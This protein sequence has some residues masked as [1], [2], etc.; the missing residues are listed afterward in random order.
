MNIEIWI[1]GVWHGKR[2]YIKRLKNSNGRRQ[3]SSI[4][5]LGFDTTN[6][7]CIA[8][9]LCPIRVCS[10]FAHFLARA[11]SLSLILSLTFKKVATL[12]RTSPAICSSDFCL[13]HVCLCSNG[14]DDFIE[15]I[16][17]AR[18]FPAHAI[19]TLLHN[20]HY[21]AIKSSPISDGTAECVRNN[22]HSCSN[23][24]AP[25][26][27]PPLPSRMHYIM[28]KCRISVVFFQRTHIPFEWDYT[29]CFVPAGVIL[30]TVGSTRTHR[31]SQRQA[32][33]N[34]IVT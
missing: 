7:I 26:A 2:P 3:C 1:L 13:C 28:Y 17:I 5:C 32:Q 34:E 31:S 33:K 11:F 8:N 15:L 18:W 23:P 10:C 22:I 14:A 25:S 24:K 20:T 6:S 9:G 21:T 30:C 12:I 29:Y 19:T 27:S 16:L 4:M